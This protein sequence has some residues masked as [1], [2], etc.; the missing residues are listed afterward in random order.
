M[1]DK[2]FLINGANVRMRD[3]GNGSFAEVVVAAHNC[4]AEIIDSTT[5]SLYTYYCEA[6]PG[7]ASSAAS[8]RISRMTNATGVIQW[9]DGDAGFDNV[10]DNRASL[11]YA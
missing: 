2:D 1:Q 8:W 7:T 9:A 10:A 3:M 4:L 5:N 11:T 6:V